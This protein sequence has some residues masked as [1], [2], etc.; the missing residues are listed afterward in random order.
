VEATEQ[1]QKVFVPKA[2]RLQA[3]PI[4][5][6]I[7]AARH[8]ATAATLRHPAPDPTVPDDVPELHLLPGDLEGVQVPELTPVTKLVVGPA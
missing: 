4:P 5:L 7:P 3:R 1:L 6:G 2:T 8:A